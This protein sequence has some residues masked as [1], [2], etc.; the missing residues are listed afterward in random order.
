ML[1]LIEKDTATRVPK[2]CTPEQAQEYSNSFPVHVVNS[3]SSTT[4]W[5][6]WVIAQTPVE[7]VSV[8]KPV[9]K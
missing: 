2:D 4:P 5:A 3:D 6:E 7:D 1:I 9:K 8:K